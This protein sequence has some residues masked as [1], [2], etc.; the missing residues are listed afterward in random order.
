MV[1]SNGMRVR[2][3]VSVEV[4]VSVRVTVTEGGGV[5]QWGS[6]LRVHDLG[7]RIRQTALCVCVCV[8]VCVCARACVV[9]SGF[10]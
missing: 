5:S 6:R 10:F 7:G 2:V 4:S 9:Q 3:R 1:H 8:C